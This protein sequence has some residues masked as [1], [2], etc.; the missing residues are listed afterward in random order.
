MSGAARTCPDLPDLVGF[1]PEVNYDAQCRLIR[2]EPETTDSGG[3]G[4][5]SRSPVPASNPDT[6]V[7]T[8]PRPPAGYER[9]WTDGRLNPHRGLPGA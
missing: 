8:N 4:T 6:V 5:T 2:P 7:T 3:S 1:D 9:V